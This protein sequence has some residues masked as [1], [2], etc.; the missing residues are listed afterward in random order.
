MIDTGPRSVSR[1]LDLGLEL[2]KDSI[3]IRWAT[4]PNEGQRAA[5]PTRIP[6]A[7]RRRQPGHPYQHRN[8]SQ[9]TAFCDHLVIGIA[10]A[11]PPRG[12]AVLVS[13]RILE[14]AEPA[15]RSQGINSYLWFGRTWVLSLR[16]PQDRPLPP[17]DMQE[18]S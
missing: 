7:H 4:N 18:P 17:Q 14:H 13:N 16:L 3:R 8:A 6:A 15:A 1:L 10:S 2:R 5:N 11:I 9:V 12:C